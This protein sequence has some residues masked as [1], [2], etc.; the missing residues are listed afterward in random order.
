M[1]TA[2]RDIPDESQLKVV[3]TSLGYDPDLTPRENE[4]LDNMANA[5]SKYLLSLEK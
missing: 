2:K 1:N 4:I 5:I 3:H